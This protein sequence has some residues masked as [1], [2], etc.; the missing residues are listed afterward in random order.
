MREVRE[1][2]IEAIRRGGWL[3][4]SVL[5]VHL[6]LRWV[7]LLYEEFPSTDI[8]MHLLGGY[9]IAFFW[10][11]AL[12][13]FARQKIVNAP[14]RVL[15]WV[16][17]FALVA[18]ATVFWEFAEFCGDSLGITHAQKSIADTML[19]MALGLVGGIVYLGLGPR[20]RAKHTS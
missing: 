11:R 14:D 13:A 4:T 18:T 3:P 2:T 17:L 5:L 7:L 1:A 15:R 6:F 8:P 19:D 10:E 12:D 20:P 9:A 16:L